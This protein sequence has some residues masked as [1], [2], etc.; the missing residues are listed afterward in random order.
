MNEEAPRRSR[1]ALETLIFRVAGLPLSFVTTVLTSRFLLPEGRGAYVIGVLSATLAAALFAIGSA[2][3]HQIGRQRYEVEAVVVRG[4]ALSLVLGAGSALVIG[5]TTTALSSDEYRIIGLC[6]LGVP[7]LLIEQTIGGALLALGRL[8]LWN[9]LQLTVPALVFAG[10]VLLVAVLDYGIEGA[11]VAWLVAQWVSAT[12]AL[13]GGSNLWLPLQRRNVS[14]EGVWSMLSLGVKTGLANIVALVN[15]RNQLF[16]LEALKGLAAVGIYS[17]AMSLAELLWILSS[18]LTTVSVAP[19]VRES[20]ERAVAV[21]AEATRHTLLLTATFGLML[22]LAGIVAVP[23]IFGAPFEPSVVPLLLLI[24][25]IVAYA[26]C[27]VISVYFAIRMGRM[28]NPLLVAGFSALVI[29]LLCLLLIPAFGASGAA[30]ASTVGYA[31]GAS[32]LMVMFVR[33][34]GVPARELLIPTVGDLS[35]YRRL[36]QSVLQRAA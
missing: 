24:P 1:Q 17:V 33:T 22:G 19:A 31:L 16:L 23:V 6:A 7:A 20:E 8:R 14:L 12:V 36:A 25:G 26:P 10:T 30:L 27:S 9:I 13:V 29:G 35:A 15:Y 4:L 28:R 21:V 18:T 3:T 5:F 34:T 32:L 2:I 11:V